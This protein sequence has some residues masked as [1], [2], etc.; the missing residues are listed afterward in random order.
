MVS[1]VLVAS[2]NMR[3]A[4]GADRRRRPERILDVLNEMDADVVALQEA[5][6][7]FGERASA[8]P[9]AMIAEHTPYVP[10]PF[11][12]RP[13]GLGW[14][15]NALLV[16]HGIEVMHRN[17]LHLPTLEPRGAVMADLRIGRLGL[18]VVGMHLDL[19]G[20]LRRRQAHAVLATVAAQPVHLP[21]V[22]MG[23][24]NE[25]RRFG[26]CLIDFAE[27]HD[28]ASTGPS[29]HARRPVGKLDRIVVSR[30]LKVEEAGTHSSLRA[31]IASDHLPVWARLSIRAD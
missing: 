11:T 9:L 20:L 13:N 14:H 31:R 17:P 27:N 3:K 2:Y 24:F 1:V 21:V 28:F 23:D 29:Y 26:G 30:D 22:M 7:R 18:R 16:R 4:I 5:D 6:H 15:G 10:V 12:N 19:S 8:L 25:W